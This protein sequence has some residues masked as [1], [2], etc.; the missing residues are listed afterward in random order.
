MLATVEQP[1]VPGA[2]SRPATSGS[3]EPTVIPEAYLATD[4]RFSWRAIVAGLIALAVI[5]SIVLAYVFTPRPTGPAKQRPA[6]V[7]PP[8]TA[9]KTQPAVNL[10]QPPTTEPKTVDADGDGLTDEAETKLGTDPQNPD[11]DG[12]GLFDGEEVNVYRTNPLKADSDGDG[13]ADGAE[14]KNGFN[15]SG[16]GRLFD[17]PPVTTQP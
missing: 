14:V 12:D 13:Y 8:A 9:P 3:L 4:R 7:P 10:A 16:P 5:V 1:P 17:V 11:A 6:A 2:G 15:P